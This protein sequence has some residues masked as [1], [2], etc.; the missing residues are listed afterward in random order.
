[1]VG[2]DCVPLNEL[3]PTR[4]MPMTQR[5]GTPIMMMRET[6]RNFLPGFLGNGPAGE[7]W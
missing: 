4:T 1:L 5:I 2:I 6:M 3:L 7:T